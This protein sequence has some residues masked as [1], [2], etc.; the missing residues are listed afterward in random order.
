MNE[1]LNL[2]ALAI[3]AIF[4]IKEFFTWLKSKKN[5]GNSLNQM[6]LDSVNKI[7]ENH[8]KTIQETVGKICEDINTGND[9]V[10][11]AIHSMH[12]DV[13]TRLGKIEGKLEK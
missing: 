8:L 7:N 12:T 4:A 13:A 11:D 1:Y 6:L 3:V 2:G 9:R 10:V 5:G